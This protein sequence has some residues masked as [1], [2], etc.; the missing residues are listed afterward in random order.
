MSISL[1]TRQYLVSEVTH[2]VCDQNESDELRIN[3]ETT[4]ANTYGN[5][6]R[7]GLVAGGWPIAVGVKSVTSISASS[8]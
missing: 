3:P 2:Q 5:A 1:H 4:A 7:L 6:L 8:R